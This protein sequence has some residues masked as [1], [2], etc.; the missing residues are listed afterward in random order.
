MLVTVDNNI[1]KLVDAY[2]FEY[3]LKKAGLSKFEVLQLLQDF[4]Y[5][6]LDEFEENE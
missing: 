3:L 1:K 4:G 6:D 2:G 5:I